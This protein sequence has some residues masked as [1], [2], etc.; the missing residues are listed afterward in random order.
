MCVF[1]VFNYHALVSKSCCSLFSHKYFE[2]IMFFLYSQ[3]L[4]K[5]IFLM[6]FGWIFLPR[7]EVKLGARVGIR[8]PNV[9]STLSVA[10]W[11]WMARLRNLKVEFE[12]GKTKQHLWNW[13]H[14]TSDIEILQTVSGLPIELTDELV[15]TYLHNCF[16]QRQSVI[17]DEIENFSR[18]TW[19]QVVIM[20]KGK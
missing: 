4:L 9:E 5:A 19:S 8:I 1:I 18:K 12:V 13:K 2:T 6:D 10:I 14:L 11:V 16:Q 20:K 15:Q 3:T 7:F 17:D